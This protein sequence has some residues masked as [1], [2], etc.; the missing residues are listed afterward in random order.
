MG[1]RPQLATPGDAQHPTVVVAAAAGISPR[2]EQAGQAAASMQQS[3][4][5]RALVA[6]LRSAARRVALRLVV[7]VVVVAL[8]GLAVA[9][10]PA[11]QA[12]AK[13]TADRVRATVAALLDM[14]VHPLAQAPNLREAAAWEAPAGASAARMAA[15]VIAAVVARACLAAT[16]DNGRKADLKESRPHCLRSH[17]RCDAVVALPTYK[18]FHVDK[19]D[20]HAYETSH[21]PMLRAGRPGRHLFPDRL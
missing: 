4:L 9:S 20:R 16:A 6:A 12:A 1:E 2:L 7:V 13:A 17:C 15:L 3:I 5:C 21:R 19:N 11:E 8:A 14:E 10:V 18:R